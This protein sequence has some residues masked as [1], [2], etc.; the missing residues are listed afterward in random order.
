MASD[1]SL[2]AAVGHAWA[3]RGRILGPRRAQGG[4]LRSHALL[5]MLARRSILGLARSCGQ[6]EI[7]DLRT[8]MC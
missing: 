6:H 1:A 7:T 8:G 3:A 4:H 5:N 2:S